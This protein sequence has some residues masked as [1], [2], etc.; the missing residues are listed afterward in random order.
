MTPISN[1]RMITGGIFLVI[2][3][4]LLLDNLNLFNIRIPWYFFT[5]QMFLILFGV[6]IIAVREKIGVGL[7]LITIGGIFLLSE[8]YYWNFW[9]IIGLWPVIFIVI[10]LSLIFRRSKYGGFDG[11]KNADPDHVDELGF[12]GGGEKMVTSQ[13]FK[14]GKLTAIF[15]GTVLNLLNARLAQGT[16]ILDVF[17]LFGGTEIKVPADM[18]VK[19]KVTAIFGGFGD[20]RKEFVDNGENED[21]ELIIKGLVLFGGGEIK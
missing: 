17:I 1:K 11:K 18:N 10:G 6:F 21:S 14:G 9:D 5:W 12:F 20:E 2:G 4:L 7:T 8:F 16:N 3:S 13:E 15:G 19:V